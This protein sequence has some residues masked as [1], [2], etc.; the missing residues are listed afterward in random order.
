MAY[1]NPIFYERLDQIA[2]E[3]RMNMFEISN[4]TQISPGLF[5]EWK[6][7]NSVP[8]TEKL[9]VLADYLGV[10]IDYLMG[11]DQ[12]TGNAKPTEDAFELATIYD[13]LDREG[14]VCVLAEAYK[15]KRR[16]I[17]YDR[18]EEA[19]EAR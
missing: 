17:D 8:G 13:V 2:R 5:S 19:E 4:E 3:R 10:S 11:R 16:M 12:Y 7:K 14:K 6:N 18:A 15:Q 1:R 9:L